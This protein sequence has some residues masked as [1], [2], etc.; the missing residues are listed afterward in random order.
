[1]P[2]NHCPLSLNCDWGI[3]FAL[4]SLTLSYLCLHYNQEVTDMSSLIL[5]NTFNNRDLDFFDNFFGGV[6]G[7]DSLT[8]VYDAHKPQ[9]KETDN[10]YQIVLAAPGIK[11][12]NFDIQVK[13]N[14]I[15]ISYDVG[16]NEN[17]YSYA[18]K[19]SKS[20]TLPTLC[21]TKSISASYE[22]GILKV[23]IP[24]GEEAKPRQIEIK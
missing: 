19:Y 8:K 16:E 6:F 11:K 4:F 21:N 2:Y 13:D 24:K 15:T 17:A 5:R 3:F 23:V 20:Y 18:S 7:N 14:K 22:D 9:V 12:E 10:D 1:M